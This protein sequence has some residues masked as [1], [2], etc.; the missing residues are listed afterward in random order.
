MI[1]LRGIKARQGGFTLS[2]EGVTLK[3]GEFVA[4]LGNNG[5]GKSTFLSVLAGLRNY[6]GGYLLDGRDFRELPPPERH[7]RISLLPQMTT[8]NM[9]FD[10]FYVVLTGRF[11]HTN[12]LNYTEA[13]IEATE[14]AMEAL[15]ITHLRKRQFNELS[16]GEKQ[17]VLLA[18][19]INKDTSVILLDEPLSGIDILHQH[20]SIRLLKDLSRKKLV[21]VV[22][23]DLSLALREFERF[24]FFTGGT[25]SY[26]AGKHE[27]EEERL[28]EI[29]G[30]RVNFLRHDKGILVYTEGR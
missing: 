4:V 19:T 3:Q 10:V 17:R 7:G 23:H 16:G 26:V 6:E 2:V 9:P 22:I 15:D 25:L 14:Q 5:S 20:D 18:R 27:L 13:D 21:M 24:L 8:L 30:V 1:E 29:F 28:S 11:I 12:G